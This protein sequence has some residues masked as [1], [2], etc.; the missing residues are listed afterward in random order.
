M[1]RIHLF[2]MLM[3]IQ[4]VNTLTVYH[5]TTQ[6][7]TI[8]L[9]ESVVIFDMCRTSIISR[10]WFCFTPSFSIS[11]FIRRRSKAI[12]WTKWILNK[13][14]SFVKFSAKFY[15][16]IR[17]K[18]STSFRCVQVWSDFMVRFGQGELGLGLVSP[19]SICASSSSGSSWYSS[20]WT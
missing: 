13:G 12:S 15:L 11:S 19:C 16:K 6:I 3:N 20:T 1:F 10:I 17:W 2:Y 4:Y 9:M 7:E 5:R 14:V 18:F 8:P